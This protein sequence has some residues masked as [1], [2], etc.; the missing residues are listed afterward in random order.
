MMPYFKQNASVTF[1]R[2]SVRISFTFFWISLLICSLSRVVRARKTA[3]A[4]ACAPLI[5]SGWLW[6]IS[7]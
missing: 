3:S 7:A 4:V 2:S 1:H 5:P 6:V